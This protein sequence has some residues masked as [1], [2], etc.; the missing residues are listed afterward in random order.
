MD[1][2]KL[3][4]ENEIIKVLEKPIELENLEL[5]LKICISVVIAGTDN[6]V[7]D[8]YR[9]AEQAIVQCKESNQTMQLVDLRKPVRTDQGP[10]TT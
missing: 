6:D 3:L 7:A 1:F 2:D 4:E 10:A 5:K 9:A 8:I